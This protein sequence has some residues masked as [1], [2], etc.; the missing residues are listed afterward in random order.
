M[1]EEA[2]GGKGLGRVLKDGWTWV[3]REC[4]PYAH[5]ERKVKEKFGRQGV[6]R[7]AGVFS[8]E[9]TILPSPL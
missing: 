8:V 7:P 9:P 5:R 4:L 3:D 2:L 6:E 1:A